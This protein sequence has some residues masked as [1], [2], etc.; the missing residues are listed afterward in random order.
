MEMRLTHIERR[1]MNDNMKPHELVRQL[2]TVFWEFDPSGDASWPLRSIRDLILDYMRA[3]S[4]RYRE[5]SVQEKAMLCRLALFE[6]AKRHIE[7]CADNPEERDK[8]DLVYTL[9][10]AIEM[11]EQSYCHRTRL[12]LPEQLSIQALTN[13]YQSCTAYLWLR[14]NG[15][16][17]GNFEA[18]TILNENHDFVRQRIDYIIHQYMESIEGRVV[19]DQP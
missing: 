4:A 12:F 3:L 8:Y 14:E 5:M 7:G 15:Q 2:M 9:C 6:A 11:N 16:M 13:G 10:Q 18:Q 1:A 17:E 19:V